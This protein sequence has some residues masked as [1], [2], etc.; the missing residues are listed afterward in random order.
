MQYALKLS[1]T[2]KINEL[3][4]AEYLQ[5]GIEQ[6]TRYT[7]DPFLTAV[8]LFHTERKYL[9]SSLEELIKCRMDDLLTEDYLSFIRKYT[10]ELFEEGLVGK[11]LNIL[12]EWDQM[13]A[14]AMP[15]EVDHFNYEKDKL[16][17]VL[18]YM[19][20]EKEFSS[21]DLIKLLKLVLRIPISPADHVLS[22]SSMALIMALA[23]RLH[24]PDVESEGGGS[25]SPLYRNYRFMEQFDSILSTQCEN[26]DVHSMCL[27]LWALFLY[28]VPDG[29]SSVLGESH[30]DATV[31]KAVEEGVFRF[32]TSKVFDLD[33]ME[34]GVGL[35]E[36]YVEA[37]DLVL[38]SFLEQM[39]RKIQELKM[40]DEELQSSL[41]NNV[42]FNDPNAESQ[43]VPRFY[44]R[45]L[46]NAIAALYVHSGKYGIKFWEFRDD[47]DLFKFL[48]FA[49]DNCASAEHMV[50]Y[51]DVL[52]AMAGSQEGA[53]FA[54][55]FLKGSGTYGNSSPISWDHFFLS[56]D[57]YHAALSE[58]GAQSSFTENP[59]ISPSD[60]LILEA[61]LRLLTTIIRE[62]EHARV[63]IFEN[64]S[65]R[66]VASLLGLLACAVPPSLKAA[67]L[68]TLAGFAKSPDIAMKLWSLLE[69]TQIVPTATQNAGG[70][71]NASEGGIVHELEDIESADEKYPE[72][73]AFLK[74]IDVMTD[75]NPPQNLGAGHRIPGIQPYIDFAINHVLLKY[76]N[77]GYVY[78]SEKWASLMY[79]LKILFKLLSRYSV[80]AEDFYDMHIDVQGESLLAAKNPGYSLMISFLNTSA[81][82]KKVVGIADIGVD[83]LEERQS[84]C[85]N[86]PARTLAYVGMR[87]CVLLSLKLFEEVLEKQTLFLDF[88]KQTNVGV[89]AT[90]LDNLLFT[91]NVGSVK[92]P[93]IETIVKYVTFHGCDE[94][95]FSAVKIIYWLSV[96]QSLQKKLSLLLHRS[97]DKDKI[98][99]GFLERMEVE[100]SETEE[101]VNVTFDLNC[102][103]LKAGVDD[104]E[105]PKS[106]AIR[107]SIMN[108]I[109][110]T[111]SCPSPNLAHFLLGFDVSRPIKETTFD[112]KTSFAE[113]SNC[114]DM[115][116]EL[117]NYDLDS[118]VG[119]H[120]YR[121]CPRLA[122][123]CYEI[124]YRLCASPITNG[125][126]M[127]YL[128]NVHNFFY[129]HLKYLPSSSQMLEGNVD[130][131]RGINCMGW[132]LKSVALELHITVRAGH[133]V[134]SKKL[135]DLLFGVDVLNTSSD[136]SDQPSLFEGSGYSPSHNRHSLEQPRIKVLEL[137]D[138]VDLGRSD[139]QPP[140]LD[141][142]NP[143]VL[144]ACQR[145]SDRT[146]V[147]FYDIPCLHRM[148][149]SD[150]SAFESIAQGRVKD[151]LNRVLE[152]VLEWN[153][154]QEV[155][156]ARFMFFGAWQQ[157]VE[158]VMKE[159]FGLIEGNARENVLYELLLALLPKVVSEGTDMIF[160]GK[161]T[162]VILAVM[163]RLRQYGWTVKGNEGESR[164]LPVDQLH[165]ILQGLL[166]ASLRP[167]TTQPLRGNL[168]GSLLNYCQ[169]VNE[170][171]SLTKKS[172]NRRFDE[173]GSNNVIDSINR[174]LPH[175]EVAS[176][177][178][179]LENG[180]I[181]ILNS[182]GSK[183]LEE[184]CRDACDG[185]DIWRALSFGT[186]DGLMKF[187][188]QGTWLHYIRRAGFLSN[189]ISIIGAEN[190]ELDH[191]LTSNNPEPSSLK[192]LFIYESRMAFLIRISRSKEGAKV[193]L[194]DGLVQQLTD[195][196]FIDRRPDD[197]MIESD[198]FAPPRM[199]LYYQLILPIL[200]LLVSLITTLGAT[201]QDLARRVI[202]FVSSHADVMNTILKDRSPILTKQSLKELELVTA[203]FYSLASHEELMRS[204]LG[205]R[206]SRFQHQMLN[207]LSKFFSKERWSSRLRL[208]IDEEPTSDISFKV[209]S[210][211]ACVQRICINLLSY[212]RR[213]MLNLERTDQPIILLIPDLSGSSLQDGNKPINFMPVQVAAKGRPPSLSVLLQYLKSSVS[214]LLSSIDEYKQI[215]FKVAHMNE[216][217]NDEVN[218]L[219]SSSLKYINERS[220]S[221]EEF[222]GSF[223]KD[224][225]VRLHLN[226][227]LDM[228]VTQ[229]S[230]LL[231]AIENS[232][233]IIWGHLRYFL[234]EYAPGE[235]G[236][237]LSTNG[238]ASY[239]T[240]SNARKDPRR[241][242]EG[243]K[244]SS[245]SVSPRRENQKLWNPL[246]ETI[247]A[248]DIDSVHRDAV[249]FLL[250]I[251]DK[252]A[253]A[254]VKADIE[255]IGTGRL[256]FILI[257][258][259]RLKGMLSN[260]K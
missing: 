43:V 63:M 71:Y 37:L 222:L 142:V 231:Y 72:L 214:T 136:F 138:A 123:F 60:V 191:L 210:A 260:R 188:R 165:S 245:P 44:F 125:P 172:L 192:T 75:V 160:A 51:L 178:Q 145:Q 171:K 81:L 100:E 166:K 42:R 249:A 253:D 39:P 126:V 14:T 89:T 3:T 28:R 154:C 206:S 38:I 112:S 246:E 87:S 1:E 57:H 190:K 151:E 88:V 150:Q 104:S 238:S 247:S 101:N 173:G 86:N 168:Y 129:L 67:I 137:L 113:S 47:R 18:F 239:N 181:S 74:L 29:Q 179:F 258:G 69:I 199:Q 234:E 16:S 32:L 118:G 215:T 70:R 119:P 159:G 226:R 48:R 40:R 236:D 212:S 13:N 194:Q 197:D 76:D 237:V 208:Y 254:G 152:L 201:H 78:E 193:L 90:G 182:F 242:Q 149:Y 12:G 143:D 96:S 128:R 24:V 27:F 207:L 110:S 229:T 241:L 80:S 114:L 161:V 227:L 6:Q 98:M 183:F 79:V 68:N 162:N 220:G 243:V 176:L 147:L 95:C 153:M 65:W 52:R 157:I 54:F 20:Y 85:K 59:A 228:K 49:G 4:A 117:M 58:N 250:P 219:A 25:E 198:S 5:A 177:R 23:C 135:L 108:T 53:D 156:H 134:N 202:H 170:N 225:L 35:Q 73:I 223:S 174:S 17:T 61:V 124:V 240:P 55:N 130:G 216:L 221:D 196:Y 185:I 19:A 31:D 230:D 209:Q 218:T 232:V 111:L 256:D 205:S 30:I 158:V 259:R 77:R 184:L 115:I 251:L 56:I 195:C 186:L 22:P 148:L 204:T 252:F 213:V 15:E 132:L 33:S 26:T 8:H 244:F 200:R 163:T 83:A 94:I 106:T 62:N 248:S 103:K 122:E 133:R 82:L 84:A 164:R 66:A 203:I 141:C 105:I 121:H 36:F 9:I 217:S 34:L 92:V 139:F 180:N 233:Y 50:A 99:T 235:R 45:D 155:Y 21:E 127:K 97:A 11:V 140:N 91:L 120:I 93:H 146:R 211:E 10:D 224:Y 187:D 255:E 116:L 144:A 7:S 102:V 107:L 257:L 169:Y 167:G 64:P 131:F 175:S 189:F 41:V 109:I 2:L 46:L